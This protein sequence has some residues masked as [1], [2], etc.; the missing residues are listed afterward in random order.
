M[1]KNW[2]AVTL[3]ELATHTSGLPDLIASPDKPLSETELDR[4]A[5]DALKYATSVPMESVPGSQFKYDQTNYLLLSRVIEKVC[6]QQFREC[7]S[8]HL[9]KVAG[10]TGTSWGDARSIVPKSADMYTALHGDRVENGANL[11]SYPDYLDAA[12]GLNSDLADMEQLAMALTSGKLLSAAELQRMLEPARTREGAIMDIG[13]NMG[14]S[15]VLAPAAGWFYADNSA[16]DYPRAFMS[17]GSAASILLLPKQK[18]C[19]VVLTNLQNKDDPLSVAEDIAIHYLPG[20]KP[21]L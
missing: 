9:L 15:G 19:V 5:E 2:E 4:S 6:G 12:A 1:P 7:V 8:S 13:K 16:G 18:V 3:R 20:L 21:M 17:G 11:F 10:M 14:I